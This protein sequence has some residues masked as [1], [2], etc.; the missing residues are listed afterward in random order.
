MYIDVWVLSG[1]LYVWL[2]RFMLMYVLRNPS[3]MHSPWVWLIFFPRTPWLFRSTI[4]SP[5]RD[6][7]HSLDSKTKQEKKKKK[8]CKILYCF[9]AWYPLKLFSLMELELEKYRFKMVF[10]SWH[11]DVDASVIG[12]ASDFWHR[13]EDTV[14]K[15]LLRTSCTQF[16]L[17]RM[18]VRIFCIFKSWTSVFPLISSSYLCQVLLII[19]SDFWKKTLSKCNPCFF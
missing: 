6:D 18:S 8:P 16:E 2:K 19:S 17:C 14:C 9:Q 11:C 15:C 1:D 5:E 4:L 7:R 13:C 10:D 3:C 12:P